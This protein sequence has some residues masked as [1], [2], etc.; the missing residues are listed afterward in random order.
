MTAQQAVETTI[1]VAEMTA[2]ERRL[3][4]EIEL[5]IAAAMVRA[6]RTAGEILDA[7]M[8]TELRWQLQRSLPIDANESACRRNIRRQ[9]RTGRGQHEASQSR[10]YQDFHHASI[11]AVEP[12]G[13]EQSC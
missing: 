5:I 4:A 10:R 2:A 12:S 8:I 13:G 1:A 7:A 9:R 6:V 11:I 3:R